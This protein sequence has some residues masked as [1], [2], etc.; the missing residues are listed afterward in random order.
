MTYGTL[1]T[2]IESC[3]VNIFNQY[4]TLGLGMVGRKVSTLQ[5][6]LKCWCKAARWLVFG[7]NMTTHHHTHSPKTLFPINK[8]PSTLW[9]KSKFTWNF[10]MDHHNI[11]QMA[12]KVRVATANISRSD[13]IRSYMKWEIITIKQQRNRTTKPLTYLNDYLYCMKLPRIMTTSHLKTKHCIHDGQVRA[14]RLY[15]LLPP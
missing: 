10:Q 3:L 8:T 6:P 4:E 7:P 13:Y 11:S 12:D 1:C 5:H 15:Q 14:V 9:N 2:N